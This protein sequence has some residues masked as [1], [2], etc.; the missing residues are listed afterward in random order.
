MTSAE[1]AHLAVDEPASE[2]DPNAPDAGGNPGN[3]KPGEQRPRGARP[4]PAGS[5][6]PPSAPAPS[7]SD[8]PGTPP[9]A[10]ST[11]VPQAGATA[12][13]G[14][15]PGPAPAAPPAGAQTLEQPIPPPPAAAPP[16]Q[17]PVPTPPPPPPGPDL[18][19]IAEQ[20]APMAMTALPMAAM[21]L[22][23]LAQAL[24]GL[25]GGNGGGGAPAAAPAGTSGSTGTGASGATADPEALR[26]R[27]ILNKLKQ[28]YAEG[29]TDTANAILDELAKAKSGSSGSGATSKSL[30]GQQLFQR[31]EAS[32]FIQLDTDLIRYM[33]K[34]A[35]DNKIAQKQI[36]QIIR[37][38]DVAL[39][40]LGPEA[41]TKAGKQKVR[42]I[43]TEALQD[44]QKIVGN[45]QTSSAETARAIENLT[46]Q[47]RNN[48]A[49]INTVASN[50]VNSAARTA[51]N[52]ALRQTGK[53]YV[54]G[55]EGPNS[56]DCSGLMQYSAAKAGVRLPRTAAQQYN[57]TRPVNGTLQPGDLIFPSNSFKG[58]N[59]PGHVI[60]YIGKDKNGVAKCI[61]AS[62]SGV[63]I[64]T[65]NLP[66]SYRAR[67]WT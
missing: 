35:G 60:M 57:A 48:L 32:A 12:P 42:A 29:D 5:P 31:N 55:A 23:M 56:F 21:M 30:N 54:W 66:G 28:L 38:V 14:A 36:D 45:S 53:P 22:P 4:I 18:G 20:V 11:P 7:G 9:A 34:M 46:N 15:P 24:S 27:R 2:P 58:A 26:A 3:A 50:A 61:A 41:F 16:A 51:I 8:K 47:Y 64:G 63:P 25:A 59:N 19:E 1:I 43:L 67:R 33:N 6:P 17:P 10:P 65:V 62:T 39:D 37:K 40:E 52:T 49:G 13:A 44:A